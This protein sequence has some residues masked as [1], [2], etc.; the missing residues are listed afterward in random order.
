MNTP[1]T[2]AVLAFPEATASV[3]YGMY[4]LFM[5]A[6]RDWGIVVEGQPGPSLMQPVVVSAQAAAFRASNDVLIAPQ[7]TLEACLRASRSRGD[8]SR[9]SLGCS[10]AMNQDR[11]SPRPAPA[12]CC[13]RRLVCSMGTKPQ[14]IGP[15]A[16]SCG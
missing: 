15:I 11:R 6:G 10:A 5:S 14:R 2:V 16:T 12:R 8:S 3:V 13:S 4:D 1:V 7:Q 9:K